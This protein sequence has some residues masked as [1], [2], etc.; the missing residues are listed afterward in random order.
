MSYLKTK[1][2]SKSKVYNHIKIHFCIR[3]LLFVN[4]LLPTLSVEKREEIR[5]LQLN[6]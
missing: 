6:T 4:R 1:C 2:I 5:N 3:K